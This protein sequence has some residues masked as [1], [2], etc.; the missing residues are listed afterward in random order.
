MPMDSRSPFRRRIA[1]LVAA[2]VFLIPG[3][4]AYSQPEA[5]RAAQAQQATNRELL[6]D[7][8]YYAKIARFDVAAGRGQE[9]LSRNLSPTEFAD[10]VET[11]DEI[12]RYEDAISRAL[13]AAESEPTAAAIEKAYQ[14]GMLARARDPNQI[15]ANIALL[16]GT[17][18]GR[19]FGTERLLRAGEYAVPQLLEALLDR[20]NPA[21]QSQAQRVLVLLGGQSLIPLATALPHLEPGQQEVVADVLGLLQRRAALPFLADLRRSAA[22]NQVRQA[23]DRAINRLGASISEDVAELYYQLAELYSAENTDLTSF[24]NEDFQLLWSFARGSGLA[25]AGIRTEV[26]HEAMAM[27]MAQRALELNASHRGALTVWIAA[28]FSRELSSPQGYQN[29]AYGPNRREA[30]YYAVTAGPA[31]S[32]AVLARALTGNDTRLARRAIAAVHKTVGAETLA[33]GGGSSPLLEAVNYPNRRVQ[34]EAALAVAAA[35]P[36]SPAPGI[37]RVVPA[38]GSAIREAGS[39]YAAVVASDN[40]TYQSIRRSLERNR[41]TVL[42]FGTSWSALEGPVAEA[43]AIDLVVV[44]NLSANGTLTQIDGVRGTAKTAATPVLAIVSSS[45]YNDLRFRVNRDRVVAVRPAG[46]TEDQINSSIATLLAEA[47]GGP[48]TADEARGY[49]MSAL[50]AL[51]DLAISGNRVLDVTDAASALVASLPSAQGATKLEIGEVL[52]RIGESRAQVA[53]LDA[54]FAAGG[55]EQTALLEKAGQS[56]RT[57]GNLSEP[58]HVTR[59]MELAKAPGPQSTTAAALVGA[60]NL[61]NADLIPLIVKD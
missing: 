28:N 10:L 46:L 51:R 54:A 27:R 23:C 24:P 60:L 31:V 37:D 30:M 33:P 3:Y 41:F 32:Q 6:R 14:T 16:T 35:Q 34:Y 9:L 59:L 29:P 21:L 11:A 15:K 19:E 8:I 56:I 25:M 48:I 55:A 2:S 47:S 49:A 26:F 43:A 61:P 12:G 18:R 22:T 44:A 1:L 13:R 7:F 38:L 40:E 36:S 50:S 5:D 58:R 4:G 42:P 53:I 57:F 52:S 20:T 17:F 45:A 39:Q